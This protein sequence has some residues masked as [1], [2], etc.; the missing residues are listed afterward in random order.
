MGVG[1]AGG[2]IGEGTGQ[3][4]IINS[5]F[6]GEINAYGGTASTT[7]VV[8]VN[9]GGLAGSFPAN[10]L[11]LNSYSSGNISAN[12]M[13]RTLNIR[14][15]PAA[16]GLVGEYG[17]NTSEIKGSIAFADKLTVTDNVTASHT[18]ALSQLFGKIAARPSVHTATLSLTLTDVFANENMD[19]ELIVGKTEARLDNDYDSSVTLMSKNRPQSFYEGIGW[20]FEYIW[21]MPEGGGLPV[22]K[23]E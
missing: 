11:I 22:L 8:L 2:L 7:T 4:N 9:A 19:T 20:D 23:W 6:T 15:Q 10:S 3:I 17:G 1:M 13:A 5:Y 18:G 21:K 14:L 12:G 16:G